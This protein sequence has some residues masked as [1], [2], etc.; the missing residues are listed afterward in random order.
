MSHTVN[1]TTKFVVNK[2][3]EQVKKMLNISNIKYAAV[4]LPRFQVDDIESRP[5]DWQHTSE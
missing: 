5:T 3:F 1:L 2:S 4:G